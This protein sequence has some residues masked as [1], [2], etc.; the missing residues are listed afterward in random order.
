MPNDAPTAVLFPGQGSQEPAMR[1]LVAAEAPDLLERC[2]DLVGEDPFAR[3]ADSTRFAQ[4]AIFCASVAG[5]RRA[6][7]HVGL[8]VAFA[9]HS[10]GEFAA[11]VAADAIDAADALELVVLRGHLM[12]E[13]GERA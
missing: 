11:L 8:P 12:W 5:W 3:V 6:A 13:A 7:P 9:G 1:D 4:P 10:L 2:L